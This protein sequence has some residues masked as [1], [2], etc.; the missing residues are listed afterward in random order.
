MKRLTPKP[1]ERW[2]RPAAVAV[3]VV[4]AVA[5][6]AAAAAVGAVVAAGPA[7]GESKALSS[8][9][10][11]RRISEEIRAVLRRCSHCHK[12]LT[13]QEVARDE[14]AALEAERHEQG[15]EGLRFRYYRCSACGRASI[16]VDVYAL[17]GES[18]E[19]F[20]RREDALAMA[21]KPLHDD[22]VDFRLVE[23]EASPWT[24]V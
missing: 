17:A 8:D 22:R 23:W 20:R 5:A 3:G 10:A 11:R 14:S 16:F 7:L 15:L 6:V 21:V 9:L 1:R 4:A 2:T 18:V 24:A 19:A 13:P 12:E